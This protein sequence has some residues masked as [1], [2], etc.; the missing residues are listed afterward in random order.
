MNTVETIKAVKA[1]AEKL[2]GTGQLRHSL[3]NLAAVQA[4]VAEVGGVEELNALLDILALPSTV[5]A[6]SVSPNGGGVKRIR[7]G[8]AECEALR[9][10]VLARVMELG[11]GATAAELAVNLGA[12]VTQ[13]RG[14]LQYLAKHG[15]I[16]VVG[17][18]YLVAMPVPVS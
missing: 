11:S 1:A 17:G 9:S 8:K 16:S 5:P 4:L 7:T 12:E 6:A 18:K 3:A 10:K 14:Q 15:A 2:G 13:V